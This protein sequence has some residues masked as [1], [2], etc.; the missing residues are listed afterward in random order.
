M[1]ID[2]NDVGLGFGFA[3]ASRF[4]VAKQRPGSEVAN[5]K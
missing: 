1:R 2:G 4:G 5:A 3:A